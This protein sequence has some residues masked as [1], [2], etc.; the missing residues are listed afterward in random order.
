MTEETLIN[1]YLSLGWSYNRFKNRHIFFSPTGDMKL[2]YT[3]D[4]RVL[5][6]GEPINQPTEKTYAQ[7]ESCQESLSQAI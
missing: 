5:R 1:T 4:G 3:K 6:D 2:I 7:L